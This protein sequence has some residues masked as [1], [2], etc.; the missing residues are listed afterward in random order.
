[1][2]TKKKIVSSEDLVSSEDIREELDALLILN[3]QRRSALEKMLKPFK[4][5]K[6]P[7]NKAK[8]L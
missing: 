3:K 6:E 2:K 4:A 5:K 8:N 7:R 1:M